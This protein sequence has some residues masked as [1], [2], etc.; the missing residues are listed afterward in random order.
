MLHHSILCR[1]S[2]L[3]YFPDY[4]VNLFI[5]VCHNPHCLLVL[6]FIN[7]LDCLGSAILSVDNKT[8]ALFFILTLS[9]TNFAIVKQLS[10]IYTWW[11]MVIFSSLCVNYALY[12]TL[13]LTDKKVLSLNLILFSKFKESIFH[14]FFLLFFYF[15]L[16]LV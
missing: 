8:F 1:Y 2:T 13:N 9:P 5:A 3:F 4:H 6:H 7:I 11:L 10:A 14:N 12:S 15:I 16:Y